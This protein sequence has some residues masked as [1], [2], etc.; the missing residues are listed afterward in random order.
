MS[1]ALMCGRIWK[2]S[3]NM[4]RKY[5]GIPLAMLE[6]EWAEK[7]RRIAELKPED[8]LPSDMDELFSMRKEI[9]R[10][11]GNKNPVVNVNFSEEY[12]TD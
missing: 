5:D 9:E 8:R 4:G 6:A 11:K 7:R 10:R 12:L 3:N 1:S 2:K